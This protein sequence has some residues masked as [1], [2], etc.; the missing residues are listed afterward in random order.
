MMGYSHDHGI[1]PRF[2]RELFQKFEEIKAESSDVSSEWWLLLYYFVDAVC[3]W[4]FFSESKLTC[5][6]H[7]HLFSYIKD[8]IQ[9]GN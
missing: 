4:E 7:S 6:P 5:F 9:S 1:I 2:T 3:E 8:P